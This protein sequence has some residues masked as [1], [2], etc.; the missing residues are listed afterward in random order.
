MVPRFG[1]GL[2]VTVLFLVLVSLQSC[3]KDAWF[4]QGF[5]TM[6]IRCRKG[7]HPCSG[8]ANVLFSGKKVA[9]AFE[10]QEG[11]LYQEAWG[12]SYSQVNKLFGATDCGDVLDPRNNS[13]MVGFRHLA[14]TD[15]IEILGYVHREDAYRN[16]YNFRHTNLWVVPRG[17]RVALEISTAGP[18]YRFT[19]NGDT[20]LLMKRFCNRPNF[21]GRMI[22]TWF[23]GQRPAPQAMRIQHEPGVT[24]ESVFPKTLRIMDQDNLCSKGLDPLEYLVQHESGIYSAY[25]SECGAGNLE[26]QYLG[27]D[28]KMNGTPGAETSVDSERG[29][30]YRISCGS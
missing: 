5:D 14:G 28:A 19:A 21:Q 9:R 11:T 17:T 13:A 12:D 3:K 16:G 27:C 20:D 10:F 29:F 7:A 25:E 24:I 8:I 2:R 4:G 15:Q 18:Y 26:V 30:R 6:V 23:G 1:R 22:G